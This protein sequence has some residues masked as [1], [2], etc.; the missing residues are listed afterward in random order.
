MKR[1]NF[2]ARILGIAAAP[3]VA[4]AA[5]AGIVTL[6]KSRITA[7]MLTADRIAK[8]SIAAAYIK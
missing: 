6:D 3:V 7:G 5:P 2:F 4:K 1:R 8:N